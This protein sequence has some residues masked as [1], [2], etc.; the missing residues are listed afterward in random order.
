LLDPR[1][2]LEGPG[3]EAGHQEARNRFV[4]HVQL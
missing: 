1:R 3:Q 2:R 4:K